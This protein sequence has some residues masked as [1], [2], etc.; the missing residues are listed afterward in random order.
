MRVKI[1]NI[2]G[3]II[4]IDHSESDLVDSLAYISYS[5]TKIAGWNNDIKYST[6]FAKLK[7]VLN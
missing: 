6:T 3:E 5:D 2:V 1:G 4:K 7:I